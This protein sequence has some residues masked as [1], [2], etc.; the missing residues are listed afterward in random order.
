M[1]NF[2]CTATSN[3]PFRAYFSDGSSCEGCTDSKGQAEIKHTSSEEKK[4]ISIEFQPDVDE[5]KLNQNISSLKQELKVL[6]NQIIEERLA[7]SKTKEKELENTGTIKELLLYVHA[8]SEGIWD[9]IVDIAKDF[10]G[11]VELAVDLAQ[12]LWNLGL[13][14]MDILD[15]LKTGNLSELQKKLEKAYKAGK[16]AHEAINNLYETLVLIL[17][18][19]ELRSILL[20]F[21]IRY[22]KSLDAHSQV[23]VSARVLTNIAV[24]I[25]IAIIILVATGGT[26]SPVVVAVLLKRLE[27]VSKTTKTIIAKL[28]KLIKLLK[29][30]KTRM[31]V[32][33]NGG[34]KVD[35][36]VSILSKVKGRIADSTKNLPLIKTVAHL[37]ELVKP[38]RYKVDPT[39]LRFT[40]PTVSP[41]FNDSKTITSL[42]EALYTGK[43]KITNE[44]LIL[45]VVQYQ[46]KLWSLDN[47]R[48]LA[49]NAA[50]QKEIL[51][52]IKP[53]KEVARE[54]LKKY[55]P[56]DGLGNIVGMARS[57]NALKRAEKNF[58]KTGKIFNKLNY[59][60]T[61]QELLEKAGKIKGAQKMEAILLKE[62]IWGAMK[63][64]LSAY[65]KSKIL[66]SIGRSYRAITLTKKSLN[67]YP[68]WKYEELDNNYSP[69]LNAEDIPQK[70]S[71][72]RI[73]ATFK[74][75]TGH[76]LTGYV[77]GTIYTIVILIDDEEFIFNR[78]TPDLSKEEFDRISSKLNNKTVPK[79]EIF[80]LNIH[81]PSLKVSQ[82]FDF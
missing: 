40:Q 39:M 58:H 60:P 15:C 49:F 19:E 37:E 42:I 12:F 28:S 78:N 35:N 31:K 24:E 62:N 11:L 47:R 2:L 65:L 66:K 27:S 76:K 48:L 8:S 59:Q 80:P 55:D 13:E 51:M 50:R 25:V 23:Y 3:V 68:L 6:L 17:S 41:Y 69:V 71:N 16:T 57:G 77:I 9:G 1:N 18:D 21:P 64:L 52:E 33:V 72:L 61:L 14:A 45:N 4:P 54:F 79:S 43:T 81:I 38:G 22:W 29:K 53:M 74:T 63:E 32:V 75:P 20:N 5:V 34:D 73:S 70:V 67:K 30:A 44:K 10:Y 36:T 26:A 7:A 82:E 46:G 56:I